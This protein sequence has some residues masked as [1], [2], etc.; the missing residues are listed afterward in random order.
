M[1][2]NSHGYFPVNNTVVLKSKCIKSK[3]SKLRTNIF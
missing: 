3:Q 1:F 2:Y